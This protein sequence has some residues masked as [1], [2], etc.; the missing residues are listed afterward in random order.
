MHCS[1]TY[2]LLINFF[3]SQGNAKKQKSCVGSWL[4][5]DEVILLEALI[6]L[7]RARSLTDGKKKGYEEGFRIGSLEGY[8]KGYDAG[9]KVGFLEGL[10][11]GRKCPSADEDEESD[12]CSTQGT[13]ESQTEKLSVGSKSSDTD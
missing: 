9:R 6:N 5:G 12:G 11:E 1:D 13:D 4:W 2:K 8:E 3:D 7:Q 10:D